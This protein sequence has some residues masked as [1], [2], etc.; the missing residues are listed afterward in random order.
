[1]YDMRY[2]SHAEVP[3][4]AAGKAASAH[5]CAEGGG[6]TLLGVAE[7]T[8]LPHI[9][10]TPQLMWEAPSY[11]L[12]IQYYLLRN[13]CYAILS[14]HYLRLAACYLLLATYYLLL[15]TC[16]L[17]LATC[18]LLLAIC[19]LLLATCYLILAT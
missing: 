13:T 16:H 15:A 7:F 9:E 8:V 4:N 1:M 6:K 5:T 3:T 12:L 10:H 17:L 11:V 14:T 2:A 18:Y 19:Y